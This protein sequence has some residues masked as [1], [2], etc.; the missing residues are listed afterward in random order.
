MHALT[1][2]YLLLSTLM[3]VSKWVILF[4]DLFP[5]NSYLLRKY[6]GNLRNIPWKERTK[7]R[8]KKE[9][10][11]KSRSSNRELP[12]CP[13]IIHSIFITHEQIWIVIAFLLLRSPCSSSV[14]LSIVQGKKRH[15]RE[16]DVW[17]YRN[18]THASLCRHNN[19]AILSW[20][21][22]RYNGGYAI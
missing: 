16:T 3:K 19:S 17:A 9:G 21:S 14:K 5:T 2:P 15:T 22:I 4:A 12:V 13:R 20:N 10:I 8:R 6:P 18:W 1:A 7:E 11:H